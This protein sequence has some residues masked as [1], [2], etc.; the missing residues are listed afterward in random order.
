MG[1]CDDRDSE[2]VKWQN[3]SSCDYCVWDFEMINGRGATV[4]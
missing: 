3:S 2:A 4:K 1:T